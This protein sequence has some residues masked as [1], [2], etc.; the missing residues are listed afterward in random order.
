MLRNKRN[1]LKF[2]LANAKDFK[3]F[4]APMK[5]KYLIGPKKKQDVF[6]A[7]MIG[8]LSGVFLALLMEFW[9]KGKGGKAK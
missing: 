9:Q 6:N 2:L 4:D 7:G 8:L 5:S 3:V 1:E